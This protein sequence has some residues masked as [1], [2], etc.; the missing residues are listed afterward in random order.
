MVT[1]DVARAENR[2]F[3]LCRTAYAFQFVPAYKTPLWAAENLTADRISGAKESRTDDFQ[4]NPQVP[5]AAQASLND[6]KG[7]K[8]DSI[9]NKFNINDWAIHDKKNIKDF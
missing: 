3:Y 5:F 1:L 2:S 4:P 9:V 7:S 8:F 6:Y